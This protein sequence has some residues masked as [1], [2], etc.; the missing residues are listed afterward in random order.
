MVC[1]GVNLHAK[2]RERA[3]KALMAL[4]KHHIEDVTTVL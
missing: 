4:V 2:R 3:L 1:K